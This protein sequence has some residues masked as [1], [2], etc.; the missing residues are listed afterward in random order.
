MTLPELQEQGQKYRSGLSKCL[1]ASGFENPEIK[2]VFVLGRP[3][4]EAEEIHLGGPTYVNQ[5]LQPLNARVVYYNEMIEGARHAYGEYM[6][7]SR[8]LDSLEK[9]VNKL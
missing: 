6:V 9:I 2:L 8:S 5:T 7:Q 4:K 1:A 3:V